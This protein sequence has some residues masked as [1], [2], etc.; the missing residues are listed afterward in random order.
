[1]TQKEA[2][3]PVI[4]IFGPT[5]Q[6]EGLMSGTI[7]HFLRT[8]GCGL[9]CTW[10]DS[11]YAVDPKQIKAN[12]QMMSIDQILGYIDTLGYAP[13]LTLTGGDPCL[14][15]RLGD[16]IV[17]LNAKNIRVAVETQG[18]LFPDWLTKVD[19]VTFSPKPPSSNN[20][21]DIDD[22]LSWLVDHRR[23]D[24]MGQVCIKVVVFTEADFRYA[25][26]V[27]QRVPEWLYDAFYFTAGTNLDVQSP[28]E[29]SLSILEAQS[30][31]ADRLLYEAR[32]A[33]SPYRGCFN[34]NIHIGCQQHVL[35]WPT[36]TMGV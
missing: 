33:S 6:G 2:K 13:W 19:C 25:L 15:K 11:M 9:R 3:I 36:E 32:E 24:L 22:M 17:P 4:E 27:L 28:E 14:Q 18:E 1:M 8:G 20:P 21:V 23:R 16:L 35:L 26:D 7:S 5:I 31:L 30:W 34:H 29:R 12:R 10:C